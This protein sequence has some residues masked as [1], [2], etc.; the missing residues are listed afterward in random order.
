MREI[1][2]ARGSRTRRDWRRVT[3]VIAVAAL[4]LGVVFVTKS[5]MRGPRFV[6]LTIVNPTPYDLDVD[7]TDAG[8]HAWTGV[9]TAARQS[10]TAFEDVIDHGDTWILHFAYGGQVAGELRLSHHDLATARWRVNIPAAFG[11]TLEA[12]HIAAPPG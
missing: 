11:Q 7:A 9:G 8:R 10:T 3:V 6:H 4:V 1:V 12:A 2:E 5:A